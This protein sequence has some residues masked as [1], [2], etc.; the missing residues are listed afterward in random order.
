[1]SN[2][3]WL[4]YS[5]FISAADTRT[6]YEFGGFAAAAH[7]TRDSFVQFSARPGQE[8]LVSHRLVIG[9]ALTIIHEPERGIF[10]PQVATSCR[11]I[12][13]RL[14][15]NQVYDDR[16]TPENGF[17]PR[18]RFGIFTQKLKPKFVG[19]GGLRW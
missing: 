19:I 17:A 10:E 8:A 2:N 16:R 12:T 5:P 6:K 13:Q 3:G 1:M 18:N 9:Y 14:L 7:Q 11:K 15:R 4:S